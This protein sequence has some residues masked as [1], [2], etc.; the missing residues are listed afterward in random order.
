MLSKP[1]CKFDELGAD[2]KKIVL[3]MIR[4][5][6]KS[7]YFSKDKSMPEFLKVSQKQ[8]EGLGAEKLEEEFIHLLN[9]GFLKII[10]E[11]EDKFYMSV[12]D[13]VAEEYIA[14]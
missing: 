9:E 6:M 1:T 8:L 10:S 7:K 12:Y 5:F 2:S 14:L 13:P 3:G 11:E 4:H